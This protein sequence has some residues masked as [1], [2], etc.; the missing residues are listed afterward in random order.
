M[1]AFGDFFKF[2]KQVKILSPSPCLL[3]ET[4][5]VRHFPHPHH[6]PALILP[7]LDVLRT[8]KHQSFLAAAQGLSSDG[9]GD[10][11]S[12]GWTGV[13]LPRAVTGQGGGNSPVTPLPQSPP[14]LSPVPAQ[15]CWC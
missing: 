13:L 9:D 7:F 5:T 4:P 8:E 10:K 3:K 6:S 12:W 14:Q 11:G 15:P 1:G 2:L